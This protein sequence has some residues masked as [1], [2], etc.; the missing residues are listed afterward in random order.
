MLRLALLLA[1]ALPGA[2]HAAALLFDAVFKVNAIQV[3]DDNGL[4]CADM[5][6]YRQEATKIYAQASTLPVFT[7]SPKLN[8]S[9]VL[10][11]ASG[12][13]DV[14]QPNRRQSSDSGVLNGFFVNSLSPAGGGILWGQARLNGNAFVV[15]TSAVNSENGGLGRADTVAHEIGHNLGLDHKTLGAGGANNLMT[16]GADRTAPSGTADIWPNG[17]RLDRMTLDQIN[18][19][20]ESKFVTALPENQLQVVD[21]KELLQ[22]R[23]KLTDSATAGVPSLFRR[24]TLDLS[25]VAAL[26]KPGTLGL[27][28]S[29]LNLAGV[30]SSLNA[31][32]NRLEI[33]FPTSIFT[34]GSV[35]T[36]PP[37]YECLT[38]CLADPPGTVTFQIGVAGADGGILDSLAKYVGALAGFGFSTGFGTLSPID[39]AGKASSQLVSDTFEMPVESLI[40]RLLGPGELG[41]RGSIVDPDP[42]A[43]AVPAP[44]GLPLLGAGL[45]SLG[46]ARR[47]RA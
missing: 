15:D 25:P 20:R 8:E 41:P 47:K 46:L 6:L 14:D 5:R 36:L 43:F 27:V 44:A 10:N 12:I 29:G 3:C 16:Q 9:A 40:G 11:G 42:V 39:Q 28:S 33:D 21:T 45:L 35:G 23:L 24:F 17:Q 1:L 7:L 31:E 19:V 32:R 2:G 18:T 13:G 34:F 30:T 38:L 22:F 4:A 26:F 37:G